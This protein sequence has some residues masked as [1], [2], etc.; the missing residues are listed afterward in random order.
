MNYIDLH[1]H[2]TISDGT[3]TPA[4]LVKKASELGLVAMALTDHDTIAGLDEAIEAGHALG[5]EVISGVEIS[6][7]AGIKGGMHMVG[8]LFDH[9]H[10][11]L[12]EALKS[13]LK[14]REE[15]NRLMVAGFAEAGFDIDFEYLAG[16]AGGDL[17]SR[18]HMAHAMVQKGYVGSR[19]EAFS[20]YIGEGKRL[21]QPKA[22]LTPEKAIDLI[23]QAGGVAVVAHPGLMPLGRST[24]EHILAGLKEQGLDG[25]EAYYTEHDTSFTNWII[26]IAAKYDLALSGG[27]DFHGEPKPNVKLGFG[28]GTLRVPAHLLDT[29]RELAGK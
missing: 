28:K 3:V 15:R 20:R 29:L 9:R 1:T 5:I 25:V 14:A 2:S 12:N 11:G 4:E 19:Q 10:P 22:K 27:S 17:I 6:V 7:D 23:H 24:L 18:A 26:R 21:Y 8:L 13:L 16:L